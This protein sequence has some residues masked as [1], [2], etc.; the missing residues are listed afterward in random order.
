MM[1]EAVKK[2]CDKKIFRVKKNITR[3]KVLA[4]SELQPSLHSFPKLSHCN[5]CHMTTRVRIFFSTNFPNV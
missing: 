3:S 5:L 2:Q 4:E 1:R